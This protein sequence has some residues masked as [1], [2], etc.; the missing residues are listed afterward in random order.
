MKNFENYAKKSKKEKLARFLIKLRSI[1]AE[2][3]I[4]TVV[5]CAPLLSQMMIQF[6]DVAI[7]LE[8][9][10][11]KK[12]PFQGT[13]DGILELNKLI[14]G[15]VHELKLSLRYSSDLIFCHRPK[16][17][18]VGLRPFQPKVSTFGFKLKRKKFYVEALHL[19]PDFEEVKTTSCSTASSCSGNQ[20]DTSC[21]G[22]SK[23]DSPIDF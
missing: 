2:S 1:T 15:T 3:N 23:K 9:F 6:S 20:N 5:S 21:C 19:P 12:S 14:Q 16:P 4:V 7:S 17:L 11:V 18:I 22:S 10:V 8:N 13:Y